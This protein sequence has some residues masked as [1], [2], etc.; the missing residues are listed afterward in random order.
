MK[1]RIV[2]LAERVGNLAP[3][4]TTIKPNVTKPLTENRNLNNIPPKTRVNSRTQLIG[5]QPRDGN[6]SG[7]DTG[8]RSFTEN[9]NSI[10]RKASAKKQ[11]LKPP[12][13]VFSLPR[14]TS[15][16]KT[17]HQRS[18]SVNKSKQPRSE[19]VNN[20]TKKLPSIP[21][22]KYRGS[23]SQT[24]QFDYFNLKV[25]TTIQEK[26]EAMKSRVQNLY[27]IPTKSA[28]AK[29]VQAS[30]RHSRQA[31]FNP[32]PN[33]SFNSRVQRGNL[34]TSIDRMSDRSLSSNSSNSSIQ[35]PPSRRNKH[36]RNKSATPTPIFTNFLRKSSTP[37]M[38][39]MIASPS[40]NRE[41]SE[42]T[43]KNSSTQN[44]FQHKPQPSNQNKPTTAE[45]PA[46]KRA[47]P[48]AKLEPISRLSLHTPKVNWIDMAGIKFTTLRCSQYDPDVSLERQTLVSTL[49][50]RDLVVTTPVDVTKS[51]DTLG[52]HLASMVLTELEKAWVVY[53]WITHHIEYDQE[54]FYGMKKKPQDALSVLLRRKGV[55]SGYSNLFVALCQRMGVV[56]K[57]VIGSSKGAGYRPATRMERINHEWV[58]VRIYGKWYLCDPTWG[59]GNSDQNKLFKFKFE[60]FWFLTR[61]EHFI[62]KHWPSEARWQ[63]LD[64]TI[65]FEEFEQLVLLNSSYFKAGMEIPLAARGGLLYAEHLLELRIRTP[66]GIELK[67]SVK[68][69][70]SKE[71]T[72]HGFTQRDGDYYV[73]HAV[74][75]ETTGYDLM[76]YVKNTYE[77]VEKW[78]L[79]IQYGVQA[80]TKKG[81]KAIRLP[82]K[83]EGFETNKCWLVEPMLSNFEAGSSVTFRIR[84]GNPKINKVSV[85]TNESGLWQQL[86]HVGG[87]VWEE[88]INVDRLPLHVWVKPEGKGCYQ[89][90]LSYY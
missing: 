72:I 29:Q 46:L 19:S 27:M 65:S 43:P 50:Y 1:S 13:P 54:G 44:F 55:C 14:S 49:A 37:T 12:V 89:T 61:P 26:K 73:V 57:N 71:M 69:R 35:G 66:V 10:G 74:F 33:T 7:Q 22:L 87:G 79:A 16:K 32:S 34:N 21:S 8:R 68:K 59:A 67:A 4:C 5:D 76:I 53:L 2:F 58:A 38:K 64:L 88:L 84:V 75:P 42:N 36:Y 56:A 62:Y 47:R 48:A 9:F 63:L 80:I 41:K 3:S 40:S 28:K 85:R 70:D 81:L 51:I 60:A 39:R 82:I 18:E 11:K 90:V 52:D 77:Q 30:K 83:G 23:D 31:S 15:K 45:N 78:E 25:L 6:E 17:G 24:T 20:N 86:K